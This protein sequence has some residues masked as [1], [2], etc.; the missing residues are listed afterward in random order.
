MASKVTLASMSV[1]R[2]LSDK[3]WSNHE[4]FDRDALKIARSCGDRISGEHVK[5]AITKLMVVR[6]YHG[7]TYD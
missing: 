2:I 3:A 7:W 4:D 6:P 1:D 5:S